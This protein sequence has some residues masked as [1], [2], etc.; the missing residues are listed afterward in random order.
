MREL[1][2]HALTPSLLCACPPPP[3]APWLHGASAHRWLSTS[4]LEVVHGVLHTR[5]ACASPMG[6]VLAAETWPPALLGL[7]ARSI[8]GTHYSLDE[9]A[10]H[11]VEASCKGIASLVQ[12]VCEGP[13][14]TQPLLPALVCFLDCAAACA[15]DSG[16]WGPSLCIAADA[17]VG[18]AAAICRAGH[19]NLLCSEGHPGAAVAWAMFAASETALMHTLP[20]ML[21]SGALL[22]AD[23]DAE[24]YSFD[25]AVVKTIASPAL[26]AALITLCEGDAG[27][28]SPLH[29]GLWALLRDVLRIAGA[30]TP[31]YAGDGECSTA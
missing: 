15:R 2:A 9:E 11:V 31:P 30:L 10:M 22:P 29:G 4:W 17:A 14:A 12:A 21:L 16:A 18:A 28:A 6:D 27:R 20:E 23:P 25:A 13:Q 5:R 1:A 19:A 7:T 3:A 8:C 26:L 24:L